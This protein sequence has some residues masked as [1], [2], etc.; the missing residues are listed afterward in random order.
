M[1][2]RFAIALSA[3]TLVGVSAGSG[4]LGDAAFAA[5]PISDTAPAAAFP[6]TGNTGV[7]D[8]TVLTTHPATTVTVAGTVIDGWHVTG[9]LVIHAANVAVRNSVID[10][11]VD[12]EDAPAGAD[13]T[14]TDTTIGPASGC[15]DLP[16]L[17]EHDYTALRVQVR[18]H[19]DG[20]RMSGDNVSITDSWVHT[21]DS[22]DNHDDGLQ[23]YCPGSV[24]H[25]LTLEH[26]TLDVSGTQNFTAPVF[27]GVGDANGQIQNVIVRDNLLDGGV[28]TV[29][30]EWS[31]GTR[32]T[33]QD[34][35]F[36]DNSWSFAPS[37][38][39]GTCAEVDWSGNT[40]VTISADYVVTGTGATIPCDD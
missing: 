8:G 5:T 15:N 39:E 19:G 31:A 9:D 38:L 26:N 1:V 35:A 18:N 34:N 30:L 32:F 37:S 29:Y 36:V 3:L 27:G 4:G 16:G 6:N 22:V 2:R 21:C 23:A 40:A 20:Y 28:F 25:N 24:C 7:P 14:V 33:V 13:T 11:W 12:N 17:G 10:G